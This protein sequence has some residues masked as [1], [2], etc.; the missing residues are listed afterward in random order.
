MSYFNAIDQWAVTTYSEE[1]IS[2]HLQ[3]K[4]RRVSA[5]DPS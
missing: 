3:N 4:S 5:F 1:Y 2:Q